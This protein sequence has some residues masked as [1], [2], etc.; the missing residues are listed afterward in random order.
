MTPSDL[1]DRLAQHDTVG[2]APRRELEWLAS[3]GAVRALDPGDVLTA[4]GTHPEGMFIVLSG[5]IAIHVDRGSGLQ[6]VMEWREGD[7]PLSAVGALHARQTTGA[8]QQTGIAR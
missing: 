8:D 4:K 3:N 7:F 2:K 5:R 6:K 1:V